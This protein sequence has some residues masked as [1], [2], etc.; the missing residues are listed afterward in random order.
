M[1][2][3]LKNGQSFNG[4]KMMEAMKSILEKSGINYVETTFGFNFMGIEFES[5]GVSC[6]SLM[7]DSKKYRSILE[8]MVKAGEDFRNV[9]AS[10]RSPVMVFSDAENVTDNPWDSVIATVEWYPEYSSEYCGRF[11]FRLNEEYITE[12]EIKAV[13][14]WKFPG[15]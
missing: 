8:T 5:N 2:R 1:Y 12:H 3:I 7:S 14:V 13:D 15:I 9:P 10:R 11:C 6:F 4:T